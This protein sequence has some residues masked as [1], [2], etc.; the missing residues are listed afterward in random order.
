MTVT[1]VTTDKSS[2]TVKNQADAEIDS[3]LWAGLTGS[4]KESFIYKDWNGNSQWYMVKDAGNNWAVNS[5]VDLTDHF[6][7]YQGGETMLNSNGTGY[8][9]VNREAGSGT[10]GLVMFSG[11]ATPVQV[12]KVDSA[13]NFTNSGTVVS[14]GITEANLAN[15]ESD[16]VVQ[17]GLSAEQNGALQLNSFAGVAEWKLKKDASNYFRLSDAVN[18]LDRVILFQNGNMLLNAGAG[19]NAVAINNTSNSGTGGLIV[20][21]GGSANGTAELTVTGSGN[22]TANGFLAGKVVNNAAAQ[23]TVSCS[24]SGSVVFSEP[25]QG[26]S[27]KKV[28]VYESACAGTASYTFPVAFVH[29][30]Q[31]LSQSL[32][33]TATTVLATGVTVT[34]STTTGFV[35][36]DGF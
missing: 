8:V 36:L 31:V 25:E 2:V 19:A 33:G 9:S 28:V 22:V 32:A 35:D 4:Q 26:S 17:A 11:G 12:A 20:Y 3:T 21:G 18:G 34:G 1:G 27:Y 6:K 13:G 10:G 7:A 29:A 30:P 24:T 5:A 15:S 23:T 16:L 14:A